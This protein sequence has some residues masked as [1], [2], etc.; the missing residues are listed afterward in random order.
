MTLDARDGFSGS[1][2]IGAEDSIG[3]SGG[4]AT[5]ARVDGDDDAGEL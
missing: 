4:T 3:D 2:R 5:A 1:P